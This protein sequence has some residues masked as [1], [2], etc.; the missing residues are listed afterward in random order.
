[1]IT[2]C[3]VVKFSSLCQKR[4]LAVKLHSPEAVKMNALKAS[5]MKKLSSD[6]LL[7]VTK[8]VLIIPVIPTKK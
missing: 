4:D 5:T 1:M 8:V 2:L 6:I 3:I 7:L